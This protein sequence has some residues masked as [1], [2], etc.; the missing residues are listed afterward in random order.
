MKKGKLKIHLFSAPG[1]LLGIL[2]SL[3]FL[4][5][6]ITIG[7]IADPETVQKYHF[8]SEAMVGHGGWFYKSAELYARSAMIQG[9]VSIAIVAVF[10]RSIVL[11]SAKTAVA[12]YML[13]T[14]GFIANQL[15]LALGTG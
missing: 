14:V 13:L 7:I 9:F 15:I 2:L 4:H 10:I 11:G 1:L 8:G 12:G 5:E 3:L 6:W